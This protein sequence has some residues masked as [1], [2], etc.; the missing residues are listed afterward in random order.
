MGSSSK[1]RPW[2]V[3]DPARENRPAEMATNQDPTVTTHSRISDIGGKDWNA[4]A[5]PA[6]P[7]VQY[8]FLSA[9]EVSGCVSGETGWLPQHLALYDKPHAA[10]IGLM[11]LYLKSHSFGEYVFDHGWADAYERAGGHYYPKLQSSVPFTPATSPRFLVQPDRAK[12]H[13]APSLLEHAVA[14]ARQRGVSSLHLTFLPEDEAALCEQEGLLLRTDQQFHWHN[15]RYHDFEDFLATL[16]SRKRK[17]IRKERRTAVAEGITIERLTGSDICERH[18]D[19][20]YT[21]YLDTGY[22]KWG[23]PY[24]NR[25]FFSLIGEAMAERILL[26]L[27]RRDGKPIA[28][29]LHLIGDDTLYGRY[30]GCTEQHRFLHF[31]ACYYQAIEFAIER[32]LSRVEAGAQGPHKLSRGYE[33]VTTRSAHWIANPG[34][35]EAVA[36][37]L[38]GE[39]AH[40]QA[41]AQALRRHTPFRRDRSGGP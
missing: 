40:V 3:F 14:F 33:P 20:F 39:R 1:S 25:A 28:G 9:L 18:W 19:S 24:L 26:V 37:Y 7:F 16:S 35:R 32:S 29:A 13:I 5:G 4:C 2:P 6:N 36:R 21:F 27:C 15:R 30:W 41:E 34:F 31:E 11:P 23:Q 10:P 8:E 38:T 17:S 12:I 22:R